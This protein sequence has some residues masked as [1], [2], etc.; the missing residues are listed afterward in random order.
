[1]TVRK[2]SFLTGTALSGVA[3]LVP[4][5]SVAE[6]QPPD[7]LPPV[8]PPLPPTVPSEIGE[9]LKLVG[10]VRDVL[11]L[12][13]LVR[14]DGAPMFA[15]AHSVVYADMPG[16]SHPTRLPHGTELV[17]HKVAMV[18]RIVRTGDAELTTTTRCWLFRSMRPAASSRS[19]ATQSTAGGGRC[20]RRS[21]A[22]T[23][24]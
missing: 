22:T 14:L 10:E 2:R 15:L 16:N 21:C 8:V 12:G 13:T 1:M 11:L 23:S 9:V 7:Q 5:G 18:K 19:G 6:A 20:R 24:R 3:S 17:R 4:V